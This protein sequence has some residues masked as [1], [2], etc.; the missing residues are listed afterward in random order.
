MKEKVAVS[1][2]LRLDI[3]TLTMDTVTVSE[4]L[5]LHISPT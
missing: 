5:A 4:T 3:Q 1:E 2:I